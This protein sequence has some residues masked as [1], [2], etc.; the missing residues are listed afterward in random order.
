[1]ARPAVRKDDPKALEYLEKGAELVRARLG[2]GRAATEE[3]GPPEEQLAEFPLLDLIAATDVLDD[4]GT[5]AF[6]RRWKNKPEFLRSLMEYLLDDDRRKNGPPAERKEAWM[7]R[8]AEKPELRTLIVER[9]FRELQAVV[10]EPAFAV[11][12][13]LWSASRKYPEVGKLLRQSYSEATEAWS[14][15]YKM[16]FSMY[17]LQLREGFD[18][19]QLTIIITALIEGL[20]IRRQVDEES[21]DPDLFADAVMAFFLGA[22]VPRNSTEPDLHTKFDQLVGG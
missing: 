6:Y 4:K 11:Q 9:A 5:G 1:M 16:L 19:R 12:L 14:S 21:V 20:A 15:A 17:G 10:D 18:E 7:E 8:L 22:V 13:H 3:S 2:Y